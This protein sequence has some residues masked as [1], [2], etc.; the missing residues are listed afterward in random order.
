MLLLEPSTK[1]VRSYEQ[2]GESMVSYKEAGV[3][4]D[5]A[6]EALKRIKKKV[7]AT[8]SSHVI[9][10]L[11]SFG[12][13]FEL[14]RS[15]KEPVLISS[16]DGVGT[17]LKL[18]FMTGV[19]NTVGH[20]LV[21][22]SVNDILVQGAEPLFFLD[23]IAAGKLD[24]VVISSV[25]EGFAD[26]CIENGLSLIGG[27]TA[28]LPGFYKKKE[29]DLAGF[30]VGAVEK[31]GLITGEHI[32]E[33]DA[34]IGLSSNGLHTNGYSLALKVLF[35]DSKLPLDYDVGGKPLSELLM[36]IHTSYLKPVRALMKS[37]NVKGMAHITGGGIRDNLAR[38]LPPVCDA[39]VHTSRWTAP[40]V[41]DLIKERGRIDSQEMFHVFN[42]GIGFV[43]IVSREET[44]KAMS[45]LEKNGAEPFIIGS[46][47]KG[48]GRVRLI[49]D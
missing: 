38:V 39:E 3:D 37:I 32:K 19:H 10:G 43:V 14:P 31:L 21:N 28:E 20:D 45:I 7:K 5:A 6:N 16:T 44:E 46:I 1:A 17:K 15:L 35:E 9:S 40:L 29:Y 42:M 33:G 26:G 4:I 22:H 11:G 2:K 8:Y 36:R 12:A 47:V 41:F 30:I 27:E 48:E 49:I 34:I 13:M 18:A 24:P 25:V 23:Y